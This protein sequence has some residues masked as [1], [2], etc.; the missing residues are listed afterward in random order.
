MTQRP[1]VVRNDLK[2]VRVFFRWRN[3]KSGRLHTVTVL[4]VI[5]VLFF[6]FLVLLSL[7]RATLVE[8]DAI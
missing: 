1:H 7:E 3:S 6:S 2:K 8:P 5:V 4:V